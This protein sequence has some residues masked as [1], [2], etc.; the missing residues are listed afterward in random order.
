LRRFSRPKPWGQLNDDGEGG[1]VPRL[2]TSC[3]TYVNSV[4]FRLVGAE[5]LSAQWN[6]LA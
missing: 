2:D 4:R 1:V 6:Y 3:P 5:P